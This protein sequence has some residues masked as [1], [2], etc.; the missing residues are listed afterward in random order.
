MARKIASIAL[1]VNAIQPTKVIDA[2]STAAKR[3]GED[4]VREL[5][6]LEKL[7][8]EFG[9]NNAQYKAQKANVENLEKTIKSF[10]SATSVEI[11]QVKHLSEVI[12]DL[13][14]TKLRNL[15]TAMGEG[16]RLLA[17]LTGSPEDVARAKQIREEMKLV[18][19]EIRKR[20]GEYVNMSQ[21]VRNLG[22]VSDNTLAKAIKQQKELVADLNATDAAYKREMATLRQLESEEAKRANRAKSAR[23]ANVAVANQ[24]AANDML[25]RVRNGGLAGM[26]QQ[27]IEAGK[28][29]MQDYMQ[30]LIMGSAGWKTYAEAVAKAE[31]HIKSFTEQQRMSVAQASQVA[32]TGLLNGQAVS[33]NQIREAQG[34]L[35]A[36]KGTLTNRADVAVVD[37]E[38]EQ[39]QKRFNELNNVAERTTKVTGDAARNVREVFRNPYAASPENAQK[40]I[41]SLSARLRQL[42]ADSKGAQVLKKRIEELKGV[43]NGTRLSQ[44][45]FDRVMANPRKAS[46]EDLKKAYAMLQQQM[47]RTRRTPTQG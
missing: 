14:G 20:T 5:D 11:E 37:A 24:Q 13:S 7:E 36:H 41:E 17:G 22:T 23:T 34:V 43:I 2:L 38:I 31:A 18:G 3:L 15:K 39:L 35:N 9:K 27:D 30:T 32:Q 28:R 33:S 10:N 26:S 6:N 21:T 16:Q 40:A 8:K 1:S 25:G 29:A 12:A 42:P 45:Q 4:L 44:E 46:V 47:Q 19:D